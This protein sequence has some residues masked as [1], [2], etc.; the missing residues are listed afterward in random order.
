MEVRARIDR[1]CPL[2]ALRVRRL[3]GRPASI[4]TATGGDCPVR[5]NDDEIRDALELVDQVPT[6]RLPPG[7]WGVIWELDFASFSPPIMDP[8]GAVK[9]RTGGLT[10]KGR[11]F[12]AGRS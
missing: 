5:C 8:D 10:D 3:R 2:E 9:R 12:L 1:A 11:R 4:G 6:T 7:M